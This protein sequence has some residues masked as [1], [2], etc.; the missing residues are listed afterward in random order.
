MTHN[1]DIKGPDLCGHIRSRTYLGKT[2]KVLMANRVEPMI[3]L[4]RSGHSAMDAQSRQKWITIMRAFGDVLWDMAQT[5]ASAAQSHGDVYVFNL[6]GVISNQDDFASHVL[7]TSLL[8]LHIESPQCFWMVKVYGVLPYG[9]PIE[10]DPNDFAQ[11]LQEVRVEGDLRRMSKSSACDPDSQYAGRLQASFEEICQGSQTID[12]TQTFR[13]EYDA[14]NKA[15]LTAA[16]K[17]YIEG[18]DPEPDVDLSIKRRLDELEA[19]LYPPI[20]LARQSLWKP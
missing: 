11:L 19:D 5:H 14:L 9:H 15:H 20:G 18:K 7:H 1:N 16:K 13:R 4:L 17:R 8:S 10:V 2:Y 12:Y 6:V 3:A